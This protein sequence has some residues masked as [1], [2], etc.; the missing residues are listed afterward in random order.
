MVCEFY[1]NKVVKTEATTGNFNPL[2][3]QNMGNVQVT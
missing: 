3:K 2:K 1:P